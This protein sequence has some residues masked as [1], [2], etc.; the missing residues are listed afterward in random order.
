MQRCKGDQ[1]AQF[2]EDRI[3][4]PFRAVVVRATVHHSM[5]DGVEMR[6]PQSLE[7]DGKRIQSCRGGRNFA[8]GLLD[9]LVWAV[10]PKASDLPIVQ[11]GRTLR[12]QEFFPMTDSVECD[13][14][15]RGSAVQA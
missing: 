8:A 2:I 4:G 13:F 15:R 9:F 5:T 1:N 7:L 11:L 6:K 12:E 3:S 10:D 14:K